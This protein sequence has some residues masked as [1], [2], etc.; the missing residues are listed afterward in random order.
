MP[1]QIRILGCIGLIAV[2]VTIVSDVILLGQPT[3]GYAYFSNPTACMAVI[4]PWRI[5]AGTL[6]GVCMLPFQL[7]GL[8]PVYYGMQPAGRKKQL[9]ALI[10]AAHALMVG[11]AFHMAHAFI[12]EGWRLSYGFSPANAAVDAMAKGFDRYWVLLLAIMLA[13]MLLC[14]GVLAMSVWKGRTRFPK[15]VAVCNPLCVLGVVFLVLLALPAPIGGYVAPTIM[16]T[17]SLI[18]MTLSLR[19]ANREGAAKRS[20]G[21]TVFA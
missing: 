12:A 17:T 18:Y 2:F 4:P 15:W 13:E 10:P 9:L 6:L 3:S 19:L 21:G 20:N 5:L 14:S 11:I 8:A 16:N 7:A 1:R